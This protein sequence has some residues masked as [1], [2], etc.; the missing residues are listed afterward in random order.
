MTYFR[1]IRQF[2]LI[3]TLICLWRIVPTEASIPR[4]KVYDNKKELED[5]NYEQTAIMHPGILTLSPRIN[6]YFD[7]GEPYVWSWTQDNKGNTFVGT[8]NDGKIFKI[9]PQNENTVFFDAEELEVYALACD[10]R[11]NI[12]AATSPEGKIYKITPAGEATVFFDPS[13]KY[14]W[15]LIFD[16]DG[17]LYAATGDTARVYEIKKNGAGKVL[18]TGREAHIEALAIGKSG[19]LLAGSVD[20]GYLYQIESDGSYRVLFDTGY[21]EV[22]S[23]S[24]ADD[25]TIYLGAYGKKRMRTAKR[26]KAKSK[27]SE[28]SKNSENNNSDEPIEL[29]EIKIVAKAPQIRQ[30]GVQE[31]STVFKLTPE[32]AREAIWHLGEA[33]YSI[34]LDEDGSLLV[35]TGGDNGKLYRLR[36]DLEETLLL[37]VDDAQITAL[38]R[39]LT[40]NVF[41]CTANMGKIFEIT[42]SFEQKGTYESPVLDTQTLSDFGMI[43]WDAELPKDTK[44][45]LFTRSGNTSD[46]NHT[47]NGW[48]GPYTQAEGEVLKSP[49]AQY[50]QWKAVLE[51]KTENTPGLKNVSVSYLQHNLSPV[52]RHILVDDPE[53]KLTD[54]DQLGEE[55]YQ[56]KNDAQRN[57]KS[58]GSFINPRKLKNRSL[59]T[60]RW[61]ANDPNRDFLKFELAYRQVADSDWKMLAEEISHN[62]YYRWSSDI[63]PDGLYEIRVTA[64]D[65]ATNP[66]HLAKKFEKLS[67]P[68]KVDNTGPKVSDF[69]A[70][71]ADGARMKLEFTVTD[72]LNGLYLVELIVD[73]GEWVILNPVDKIADSKVEKFTFKTGRLKT[74]RHSVVIRAYDRFLNIGYGKFQFNTK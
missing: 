22:H 40:G 46:V 43:R 74:G 8:G 6:S 20:N 29:E 42:N 68:F 12:L 39:G 72:Q 60:V 53:E 59:R 51:T 49:P 26:M 4:I 71:S 10:A 15:E 50:L 56:E 57:S 14:I 47:W 61:S 36:Q 25:G 19:A 37:D 34:V 62:Y 18:F 32:G 64:S 35:G 65:A 73:A 63:W 38:Y 9:T 7:S 48:D 13:D 31:K 52:I 55:L 30:A 16:S 24:V 67:Q 41:M 2:F 17:N 11:N 28:K 5:G 54:P 21:R 1:I 44:I 66:P 33:V 45:R 27:P 69:S 3:S 23:I 58:N 70:E